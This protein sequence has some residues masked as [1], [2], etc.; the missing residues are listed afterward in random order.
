MR[1][2]S[3][4]VW[5]DIRKKS[6][7]QEERMEENINILDIEQF[8]DYLNNTYAATYTKEVSGIDNNGY[9]HMTMFLSKSGYN[10]ELCYNGKLIVIGMNVL[11]S[12]ERHNEIEEEYTTEINNNFFRCK[13]IF[14]KDKNGEVNNAFFLEV[15]ENILDKLPPEICHITK[16]G[17]NESVWSDIRKKSLG[18]EERRQNMNAETFYNYLLN[19][20]KLPDLG[21]KFK[22]G[23]SEHGILSI[24]IMYD[25]DYER[26]LHD[27]SSIRIIS[28]WNDC[29][30]NYIVI[31]GQVTKTNMYQK[32]K[33]TF[34]L[35]EKTFVSAVSISPKGGGELTTKFLMDLIDFFIDNVDENE[36]LI[37]RK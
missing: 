23:L 15:L 32:I 31:D 5:G 28:G 2:L 6:L 16:K 33:D 7:G 26:V 3:E 11:E 12:F 21:R 22:I 10:C 1:K 9:I 35:D 36:K 25:L 18:Q 34:D 8:S 29:L 20:Y 37:E 30:I 17:M 27:K 24:P 13:N 4:S 14:P 19:H